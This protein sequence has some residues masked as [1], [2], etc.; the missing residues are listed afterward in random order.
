MKKI[1][2]DTFKEPCGKWSRKSL[3]TFVA[4]SSALVYEFILPFLS[5]RKGFEFSHNQYV[6]DGL[7]LLTA[8]SLGFTVWAKK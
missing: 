5:H 4:F 8:V 1:I 3:T 7:L 6:F 2:N